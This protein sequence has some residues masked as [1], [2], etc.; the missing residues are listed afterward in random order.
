MTVTHHTWRVTAVIVVALTLAVTGCTDQQRDH[1]RRGKTL[2]ERAPVASAAELASSPTAAA[3]NR[4]GKML[5]GSDTNLPLVAQRNPA[6][7]QTEGFDATLSRMLAKYITGSPAPQT[8]PVSPDDREQ[9]LDSGMVDAVLR[10]YSI[11]TQRAEK[12]DFA[13]PY[14]GSGQ[15][16]ATLR[17]E[18]AIERS[19]DL[20]GKRVAVVADTTSQQ[21]VKRAAPSAEVKVLDKSA[22][23]VEALEQGK[24]D[25]YVHD[26]TVV[27]G[28]AQLNDKIRVVGHPFT[29]EPYGIGLRHGDHAF[30]A[31]VNRWLRKIEK[32]G[33]WKRAWQQSL[34]TIVP[35]AAPPPPPIGETPGT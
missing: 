34:G 19:A 3:I 24:V 35:G 22:Q 30:K 5:V 33:L 8:V 9:M 16:I 20:A 14:L 12:V 7:G 17:S 1:T 10:I 6:T 29:S 27:A 25:A 15:S 21:A 11:T 32:T 26:L 28:A 4:R 31:F 18:H 2:M 23:C 13:G